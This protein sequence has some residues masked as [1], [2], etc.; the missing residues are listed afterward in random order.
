MCYLVSIEY[1]LHRHLN[2]SWGKNLSQYSPIEAW[3]MIAF[4][5]L[6]QSKLECPKNL[7]H[8]PLLEYKGL[9][10]FKLSSRRFKK[11]LPL[12]FKS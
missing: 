7:S 10:G 6:T 5:A 4:E 2:S 8:N 1:S 9:I 11:C 3:L 12:V